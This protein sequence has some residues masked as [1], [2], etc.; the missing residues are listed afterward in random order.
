M[1]AI[2][3]YSF[4]Y[5][6]SAV[7]PSGQT[8]YYSYTDGVNGNSVYVTSGSPKPKGVLTIP[9]SV[10]N[11]SR[12]YTVTCIGGYAFQDCS[13]LT[14]VTI[15]NSVISIGFDAFTYCSGLTSVS[16]PNSVTSI[17]GHAFQGCSN[18]TSVT[19]PNSVTSIGEWAF[20]ECSNLISVSIGNS[21]TSIVNA[22]FY[23]C[24]NLT[25]V[26]IPNS[27][28]RIEQYAFY[29]CSSLISV[30]IP[31]AV[32]SIGDYAF[33]QCSSLI[34]VTIPNSVTS[35]GVNAFEGCS[36]LTS[37]TIPNSVTSIEQYAFGGCW[38][39]TSVTIGNSVTNIGNGAFSVCSG[40]TEI[41]SLAPEPPTNSSIPIYV[42]CGASS[43][44]QAAY[45]WSDF[46]NIQER[47]SYTLTAN[48][49]DN[50]M[51]T[52]DVT[53]APTCT[54]NTATITATANSGYRFDHWSDGNTDNPRTI[55]VTSDT[56][57]S[58]IFAQ[59]GSSC[60]TISN[61]T[62]IS[63]NNNICQ[64]TCCTGQTILCS[65]DNERHTA[66][67]TGYTEC[68]G[69]MTIPEAFV[70]ENNVYTITAIGPRAFYECVGLTVVH[71]PITVVTYG[72]KAFAECPL[73]GTMSY[74]VRAAQ[75]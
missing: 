33:Y 46:T 11:G 29:H 63:I 23:G 59:A 4:A 1:F 67:V 47:F 43:N 22:T 61:Q 26:T 28:T 50:T 57:I 7:A 9:S 38:G 34:S 6:F 41:H 58:A 73:L 8:L 27:V 48:T 53:T 72:E 2:G 24:S 21:V 75:Q 51:G 10:R 52:A 49:A 64:V 66:T 56:S 42:P 40:L 13:N 3:Q 15:P 18:L 45:G 32:T 14:S 70:V 60:D 55:T 65:I 35:I 68:E 62:N 25:S 37:V 74:K 39:L 20:Y 5:D 71:L 30:T 19:I 12:D 16:I 17:G 69:E 36:G 44:Y 31:N 54:N